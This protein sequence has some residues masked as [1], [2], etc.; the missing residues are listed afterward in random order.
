MKLIL[1]IIVMGQATNLFLFVISRLSREP[2]LLGDNEADLL[3]IADPVPQALILTA[4]VIGFG[5]QAFAMVLL[6][7][8]YQLKNTDD[9]DD[10]TKTDTF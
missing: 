3:S 7:T 9:L 1:G 5:I 2:A 4:I 8:A 6:K 10:L